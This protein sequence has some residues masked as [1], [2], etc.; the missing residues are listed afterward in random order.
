MD[1][2]D[3]LITSA[4]R[5]NSLRSEVKAFK[6]HVKFSGQMNFHLHEDRVPKMEGESERLI[7]WARRKPSYFTTV[8]LSHPRIG[9]GPALNL[10]RKHAKSKY[11]F[12]M[13]EDFD[14]IR[15]VDLDELIRL[16]DKYTT[17]NQI[18]FPWR[19]RTVHAKPGGP[20]G[21]DFVYQER[22]FDDHVMHIPDRWTWQPALWRRSWVMPHWNF[23]ARRSNKMFNR[24]FK[25]GCGP[26]EWS[27]EWLE[28]TYGA[29]FYSPVHKD[30]KVYVK[31]T[32]WDVRHDREFL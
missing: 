27:A 16:M 22:T 30:P 8:Y 5:P 1:R 14:F 24:K 13:E 9:R 20:H 32:S 4:S 26:L 17:I 23:A 2:I 25:Q 31:H 10:L 29:Y 7:E 15:D 18:A 11:I 3:I 12:Y 28:K 19:V 6:K 21:D